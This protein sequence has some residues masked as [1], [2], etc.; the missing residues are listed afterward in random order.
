MVN[1]KVNIIP[2]VKSISVDVA[3]L[4]VGIDIQNKRFAIEIVDWQEL[5][6]QRVRE[7]NAFNA[8]GFSLPSCAN[9]TIK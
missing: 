5:L 2:S 3:V 7:T 9:F 8:A 4:T 1:S 6:D